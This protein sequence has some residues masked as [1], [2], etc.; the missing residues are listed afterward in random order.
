MSSYVEKFPGRVDFPKTFQRTGKFPLDRTDMFSSYE[1]AVKY[2]AGNKS[3]PDIR[4]LCG[5]SYVGQIITVYENDKVSVYIIDP[6]RTIRELN[7]TGDLSY[8]FSQSIASNEWKITHNLNKYPSVSVV[9][10]SGNVVHGDVQYVDTNTVILK[11]KGAFS[12]K[13]HLN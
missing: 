10:S 12:G 8:T 4:G 5:T 6:D 7:S 9:D 2:A 3:D 13:A 1:D 11:F